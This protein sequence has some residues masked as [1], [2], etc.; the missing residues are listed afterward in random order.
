L[1]A[2][3]NSA[4]FNPRAG[5]TASEKIILDIIPEFLLTIALLAAGLAARNIKDERRVAPQYNG[6]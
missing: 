3:V 6:P 1:G 2:F 5:G 4:S